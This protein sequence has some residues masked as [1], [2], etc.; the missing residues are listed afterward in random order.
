MEQIVEK[1][2]VAIPDS[3]ID[4]Q[5]ER[6][7]QDVI[8]NLV[9]RGQTYQEFLGEIGKSEDE[10]KKDELKPEA[11]KRLKATLVLTEISRKEGLEVTD[12]EV[13]RQIVSLKNSNPSLSSDLTKPEV[14]QDI[15]SRLLADKTIKVVTSITQK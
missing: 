15:A 12:T 5:V 7:L 14:K 10:Y 8:Q 4:D 6:Q 1:S 11:Q 2:S 13:E 3:L 9:Y